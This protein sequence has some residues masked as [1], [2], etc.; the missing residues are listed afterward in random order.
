MFTTEVTRVTTAIMT[1]QLQSKKSNPNYGKSVHN[2]ARQWNWNYSNKLSATNT[3][4]NNS[5][6]Q[7]LSSDKGFLAGIIYLII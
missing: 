3:K 1:K 4:K 6:H 5:V 7:L 2:S